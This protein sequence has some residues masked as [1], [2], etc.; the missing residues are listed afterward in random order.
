M[1]IKGL[2]AFLARWEQFVPLEE[3]IQNQSVGLDIFWWIHQSKGDILAF[4]ESLTPFF[5]WA[6]AVHVV[7]DG[8][9]TTQERREELE[10]RRDKRQGTIEMIEEIRAAPIMG[11]NDQTILDRYLRQLKRQIWKPSIT[12]IDQIKTWLIEQGA[13]IHEPKGEADEALIEMEQQGIIDRIV[14]NDSDLIARGAETVIRIT[15]RNG[16]VY[17]KSHMRKQMGFTNECWDEFM[18][19]CQMK[20]EPLVAYSLVRVYREH[21][22]EKIRD[23]PQPNGIIPL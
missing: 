23:L 3:A 4:Q 22:R 8:K 16:T 2:F 6:K 11:P 10:E 15:P 9:E 21:A 1:G 17:S 14:T 13:T 20:V 7:L 12:Y 19:L 18:R 5:E